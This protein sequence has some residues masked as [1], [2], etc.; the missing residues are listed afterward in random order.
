MLPG[1]A[2]HPVVLGGADGNWVV[3][4]A[5]KFVQGRPKWDNQS[6]LFAMPPEDI[7][8]QRGDESLRR[9][10]RAG[11][12]L[13][14][15]ERGVRMSD[16]EFDDGFTD[17]HHPSEVTARQLWDLVVRS[18]VLELDAIAT[19]RHPELTLLQ[20]ADL[21]DQLPS[22]EGNELLTLFG[23]IKAIGIEPEKD[24]PISVV[25]L[26]AHWFVLWGARLEWVVCGHVYATVAG[27]RAAWV[28]ASGVGEC[29]WRG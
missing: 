10:L 19:D 4:A 24:M 25:D 14:T 26:N 11:V 2:A 3:A 27:V 29:A 22:Y 8:L 28:S 7:I 5:A 20:L 16:K 18:A 9:A 6:E 12:P 21:A 15:L 1:L 17:C 13:S 23:A